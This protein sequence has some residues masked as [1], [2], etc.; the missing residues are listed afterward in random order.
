MYERVKGVHEKI[1]KAYH[2]D[3]IN[4]AINLRM[5]TVVNQL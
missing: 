2:F 5:H 1:I 3:E 4:L